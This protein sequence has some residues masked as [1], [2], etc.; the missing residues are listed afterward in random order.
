MFKKLKV[1]SKLLAGFGVV[2]V[3]TIIIAVFSMFELNKANDDLKEFMD[4]SVKAD[5]LIKD[6]RISTNIAARYLRDM[7][8]EEDTSKYMEKEKLVEDNISSI[9]ENFKELHELN[10]LDQKSLEA[11]EDA[12]EDWFDIGQRVM[13]LLDA[14]NRDGARDV[15]LNECT[16]ALN[17]VV[18]LVKPLNEETDKIRTETVD[19]SVQV[20]NTGMMFLLIMSLGAIALGLA[21][22]FKVTAA[23]VKPV[24]LVMDA[25][26]SLSEGNMSQNISYES[27]D[28]LGVLVKSVQTT[29]AALNGVIQD[30]TYLMGQMAKG[31]F[32]LSANQS[33]YKGD[34]LPILTSIREM[35]Y[36]LSDT[37]TQI[38]QVSDQVAEGADQVS[39]G[40]QNLSEASAE[41][42]SSVEQLAATITEISQNIKNTADNAKEASNRVYCAQNE[43]TV[44]NEEMQ[45]MIQAMGEIS[46]KS[47][48]I[49]KIIK[50]IEDI[51]FQ[52]NI[53]ALNA[54]VEAAR[55]GEAG[56]GFAVVADEV[57][58]LA[59]KSA[60]AAKNTTGLIEGTIEAVNNGTEIANKTAE[61]L[62]ATVESTKAAV[63]YVDNISS[64]AAEQAESVFQVRQGVDQ[65]AGIVQTNSATAEESAAASEEMSAQSQT[66]KNLVSTFRLR[67]NSDTSFPAI[68]KF[69]GSNPQRPTGAHKT[70]KHFDWDSSLETGNA[71]I[72]SQHRELL[73]KIN[74]LLDACVEGRG[75]NEAI[76]TVEFLS[77]YTKKHFG[78]EEKLQK[79][80]GYPDR[81]KHKQYHEYF[82]RTVAEIAEQ[83][84]REG[85]SIALIGKINSNVGNWLVSHIKREDTKVA[86]HIAE[87]R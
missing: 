38:R 27:E 18:Q 24:N 3:L 54:A 36:N 4:G 11:Y 25:M 82:K 23:I 20:T 9:R 15:I 63:D 85:A 43:L 57:R 49:G 32:D 73:E 8:L 75:R 6:N 16:P 7:V 71:M 45:K 33:V 83:L 61:A 10:V 19:Q 1:K 48:D 34:L 14:K 79:Q 50:T 67:N 58:N 31:N 81:E 70:A 87:Q 37:L 44:S 22:C 35:N 40:A 55:A 39:A 86:R 41:Q 51:A 72:D 62:M 69:Q 68:S 74:N 12:M 60:E 28:E 76:R 21:I 5:D 66:L 29:C 56:R 78:D 65:I 84:E 13:S 47:E 26:E 30:L 64:S 77:D 53:L 42:A 80:Y 46:H 17:K 2:L 59:S 52:T